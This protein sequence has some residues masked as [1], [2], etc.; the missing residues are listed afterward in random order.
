MEDFASIFEE[1]ETLIP[2]CILPVAWPLQLRRC[3]K[4]FLSK[5]RYATSRKASDSN[6]DEAIEFF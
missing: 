4:Y 1:K 6:P 5:R 2:E 3:K